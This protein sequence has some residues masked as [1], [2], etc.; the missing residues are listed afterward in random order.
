MQEVTIKYKDSKTLKLLKELSKYLDFVVSTPKKEEKGEIKIIN[1]V[2]LI[3]GSR[4][5][6]KTDLTGIFTN[7]DAKK[8]RQQAWQRRK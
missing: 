1:G 8:L 4:T 7:V 6:D 2:T 3:R 5:K